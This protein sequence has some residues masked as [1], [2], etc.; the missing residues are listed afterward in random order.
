MLPPSSAV[1]CAMANEQD[2]N[3]FNNNLAVIDTVLRL[4]LFTLLK[5][6]NWRQGYLKRSKIV[7]FYKH[8]MIHCCV[9]NKIIKGYTYFT[10]QPQISNIR[11]S[12]PPGRVAVRM[13]YI[14]LSHSYYMNITI[15]VSVNILPLSLYCILFDYWWPSIYTLRSTRVSLHE[16]H[17]IYTVLFNNIGN[18]YYVTTT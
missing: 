8:F 10:L 13:I 16:M 17:L 15:G 12:I 4:I 7:Y 6:F 18:G 5:S 1:T 2:S 14:K 9:T 11:T 3:I